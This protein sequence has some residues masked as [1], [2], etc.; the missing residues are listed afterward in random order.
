[1]FG[2]RGSSHF[3]VHMCRA[4]GLRI[5]RKQTNQ[6]ETCFERE[7]S[8]KIH[9]HQNSAELANKSTEF[10]KKSVTEDQP[11]THV[12]LQVFHHLITIPCH[13][14]QEIKEKVH[15]S[16]GITHLPNGLRALQSR[17][18]YRSI[19]ILIRSIFSAPPTN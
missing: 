5:R 11:A 7:S 1:M 2:D 9:E 14:H 10:H 4:Q 6:T 8:W 15:D 3:F 12:I 18:I 17:P 16:P 19:P 13:L